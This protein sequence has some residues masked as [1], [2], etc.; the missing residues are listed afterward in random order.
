MSAVAIKVSSVVSYG[1]ELP[2]IKS[3]DSLN[4]RSFTLPLATKFDRVVAYREVF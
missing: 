4:K 3:H 1:K 2:P